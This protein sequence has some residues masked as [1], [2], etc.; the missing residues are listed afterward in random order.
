MQPLC[1]LLARATISPADTSV[2]IRN[3]FFLTMFTA[4]W[5][6]L[7]IGIARAKYATAMFQKITY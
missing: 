7:C 3:R 2:Q 5:G 6:S 1:L 4:I